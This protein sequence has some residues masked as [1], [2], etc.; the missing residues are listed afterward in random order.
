MQ[1]RL[2]SNVSATS[3]LISLFFIILILF[4]AKSLFLISFITI[5]G[6][7]S[8]VLSDKNVKLYVD[9]L[10]RSLFVLLFF[11]V[12]YIIFFRDIVGL[13]LFIYKLVII[14]VFLKSFKLSV[15][16]VELANAFYTILKPFKI[17]GNLEKKVHTI[18]HYICFC[19][20]FLE[21]GINV[22]K[23]QLFRKKKINGLKYKFLPCLF[24]SI[25]K[26]SNLEE[27]LNLNFYSIK[28][29]K[30][31]VKSMFIIMFFI[32]LFVLAFFK[33]VVL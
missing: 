7:I 8:I 21:S 24:Y 1:Q 3:K 13:F 2:I 11:S 26:V 22:K 19:D 16:F 5:L 33:E 10:K 25:D 29:E 18:V 32:I 15:N 9:V 14:I 30:Q 23:V 20:Y 12:I 28:K 6:I 27:C 31:N 4:M 17:I